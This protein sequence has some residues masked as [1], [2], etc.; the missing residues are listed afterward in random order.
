M[1]LESILSLK[2]DARLLDAVRRASERKMSSEDLLEQRI[3]FVFGS[4]GNGSSMTKERVREVLLEQGG[5]Q[6]K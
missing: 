2:T 1:T 5:L 6:Q 4:M 3:S